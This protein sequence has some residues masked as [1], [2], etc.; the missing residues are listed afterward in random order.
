MKILISISETKGI[1]AFLN[2]LTTFYSN[3]E[4]IATSG[5]NKYLKSHNINSIEIS[6]YINFREILGG[7]VKSLH[8]KIFGGI[9]SRRNLKKHNNETQRN[10]NGRSTEPQRTP[11]IQH[12]VLPRSAVFLCRLSLVARRLLRSPPLRRS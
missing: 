7:R 8:P 12:Q 6:E 9:L 2:K 4:I 11:T 1:V 5:T 10:L 3:I